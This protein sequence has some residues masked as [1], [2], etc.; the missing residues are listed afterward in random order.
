MNAQSNEEKKKTQI[1]GKQKKGHREPAENWECGG[2]K[3]S[4]EM[5]KRPSTRGGKSNKG[6]NWKNGKRTKSFL[7]GRNQGKGLI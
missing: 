5:K 1:L 3:V 4:Y 6:R 7:K 2:G